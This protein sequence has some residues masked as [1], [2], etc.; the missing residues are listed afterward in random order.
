MTLTLKGQ[1]VPAGM[2]QNW[3]W[4]ALPASG[5]SNFQLELNASLKANAPLKSS[6]NGSLSLRTDTQQV[7]QQMQAGEVR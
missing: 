3:G 7:Q 1:A 5:P 2:L 4:P 6:A